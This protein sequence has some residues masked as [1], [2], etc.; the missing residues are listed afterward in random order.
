MNNLTV[1]FSYTFAVMSGICFVT[2]LI[3][4]IYTDSHTLYII[5]NNTS[6]NALALRSDTY[7]TKSTE[8]A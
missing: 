8:S 4:I 7:R 6:L 1:I 3:G 5:N 2:G